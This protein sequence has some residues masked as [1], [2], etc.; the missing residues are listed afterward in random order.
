[1]LVR[2]WYLAG[3]L[4]RAIDANC[5][6]LNCACAGACQLSS[7][8]RVACQARSRVCLSALHSLAIS[9]GSGQTRRR[10]LEARRP[11]TL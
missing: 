2:L 11:P 8:R 4:G 7:N 10:R 5:P 9:L 3:Y 1:M 6:S